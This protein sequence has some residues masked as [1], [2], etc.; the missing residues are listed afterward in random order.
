MLVHGCAVE[1]PDDELAD[2]EPVDEELP[3]DELPA[4]DS[5]VDVDAGVAEL[6][7]LAVA[8]EIPTPRLRAAALAAI[9]AASIGCF[10]FIMLSSRCEPR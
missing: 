9:P 4:A 1:L 10:S 3:V 7:V 5:C 6:E 8:A 2:D